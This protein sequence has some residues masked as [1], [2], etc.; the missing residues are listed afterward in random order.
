[1]SVNL[2]ISEGVSASWPPIRVK[3]LLSSRL[4]AGLGPGAG[5]H[6]FTSFLPL[7]ILPSGGGLLLS[8]EQRL[9]SAL[10]NKEKV[11]VGGYQ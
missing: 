11:P 7:L 8:A 3:L 10:I 9:I 5:D 2:H 6:D 4:P 1:M